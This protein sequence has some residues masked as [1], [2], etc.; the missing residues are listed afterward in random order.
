MKKLFVSATNTHIGKTY[1]SCLLSEFCNQRGIKT[2]VLKPIET[3]NQEGVVLDCHIHWEQGKRV[4]PDLCLEDVNFY[5]YTL[6][7]SPFVAQAAESEALRVDFAYIKQKVDTMAARCDFVIIEGAGGIMVPIDAYSCMID[8]AEYLDTHLLLVSG[9]RL[10]M[11]NDLLLNRE[12]LTSRGIPTTYALNIR[13][14]VSYQTISKPY[15]DYLNHTSPDTIYTLQ[16]QLD[17]IV[18]AVFCSSKN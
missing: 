16:T 11:I 6:P 15:I 13:D 18:N 1:A 14:F 9:D 5:R 10:G 7:A 12:F 3:G 8:L 17:T 2:I 4:L